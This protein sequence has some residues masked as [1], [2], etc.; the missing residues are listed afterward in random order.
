MFAGGVPLWQGRPSKRNIVVTDREGLTD[1]QVEQNAGG[2]IEQLVAVHENYL[3]TLA[4]VKLFRQ[5]V[6]GRF[7]DLS[8]RNDEQVVEQD[9][10]IHLR[11]EDGM[12]E[13]HASLIQNA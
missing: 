12:V 2:L 3:S 11:V 1:P 9:L 7:R 5:P 6:L 4:C 13:G 8:C 10:A